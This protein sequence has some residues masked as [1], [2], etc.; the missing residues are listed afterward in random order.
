MKWWSVTFTPWK[1]YHKSV[2]KKT[3]VELAYKISNALNTLGRFWIRKYAEQCVKIRECESNQVKVGMIKQ[4]LKK[5]GLTTFQS[6]A[7]SCR[8]HWKY[9]LV[10]RKTQTQPTKDWEQKF[11]LTALMYIIYMRA[12]KIKS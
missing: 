11:N 6:V 3:F 9:S 12:Y 2:E 7:I 5:S 8:L 4:A 1:F 10:M